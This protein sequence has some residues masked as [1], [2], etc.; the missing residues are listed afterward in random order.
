MRFY[1]DEELSQAIA[2]IARDRYGLDVAASHEIGKD[3][4]TDDEQLAFAA[5][6]GRCIVTGNDRHFKRLTALSR[7]RATTRRCPHRRLIDAA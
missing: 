3:R 7:E 5:Q 1:L 4:A 6:L 2:E